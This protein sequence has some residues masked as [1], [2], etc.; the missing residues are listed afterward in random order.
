MYTDHPDLYGVRVLVEPGKTVPSRILPE[1]EQKEI[2]TQMRMVSDVA[3]L[4]FCE[5]DEWMVGS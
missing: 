3:K 4:D 5:D 1:V 2:E